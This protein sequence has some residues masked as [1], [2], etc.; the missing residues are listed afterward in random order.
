MAGNGCVRSKAAAGALLVLVLPA[1]YA[2]SGAGDLFDAGSLCGTG[3]AARLRFVRSLELSKF[4]SF[5]SP[6]CVL[7]MGES[8][9]MQ[10]LEQQLS[11]MMR[12]M[13]FDLLCVI[14]G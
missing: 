5:Q 12:Y 3:C 8:V 1:V 9:D 2:G 7:S 14:A 4:M 10:V 6:L 11:V 13:H